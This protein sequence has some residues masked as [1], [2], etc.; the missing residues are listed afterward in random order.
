[1]KVIYIG[2]FR[3]ST[4]WA[5]FAQNQILALDV[6]GV[7]V[8]PRCIKLNNVQGKVPERI[9][10]LESKSDRNPDVIIQNVL[11]HFLQKTGRA[12]NIASYLVETSNF[13]MTNWHTRINQMDQAWVTCE[14]SAWASKQSG[15]RIPIEI[16]PMGFDLEKYKV[17]YEPLALRNQFKDKF[18]FYY[19]GE[20]NSRKNIETLLKAFHLEF[21]PSEPVELLIKTTP[22]GLGD[23]PNDTINNILYNVKKGLKLYQTETAYKKEIIVCEYLDE[24][25]MN[26]LHASCDCFITTARGEGWNIP[27]FEA[28]CFNKDVIVPNHTAFQEWAHFFPNVD[29]IN[30]E[31]TRVFNANDAAF[32]DIYTGFENWYEVELE[33][34]MYSMRCSFENPGQKRNVDFNKIQK[35]SLKSVG[36][37]MKEYLEELL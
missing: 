25:Q 18:I 11:P 20:L 1:M 26:R 4:G 9:L 13:C 30:S 8:I 7:E 35:F 6:A 17:Q 23:N 34:L 31:E 36:E 5:H 15:V 3:D 33:D 22:V 27:G 10:E 29:T 32:Q 12:K 16:I 37:L 24:V 14:H 2:N 21:S 28:A 19:I